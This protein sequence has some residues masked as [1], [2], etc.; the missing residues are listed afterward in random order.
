MAAH[1]A[2]C[3]F[4]AFQ[5]FFIGNTH[6]M[7]KARLGFTQGYPLINLRAGTVHQ[8][9]SHPQTAQQCDILNNI[10][11]VIVFNGLAA[12]H[13]HKG[14]TPVCIDVRRRASE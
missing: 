5:G 7:T 12:K 11:K 6:V 1:R 2:G 4:H 14:F 10:G 13:Q 3:V 9:Q 8:H